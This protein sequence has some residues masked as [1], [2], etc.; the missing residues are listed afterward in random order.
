[1]CLCVHVEGGIRSYVSLWILI[2]VLK[3]GAHCAINASKE[4]C[5]CL[6]L[7]SEIQ[8]M[9]PVDEYLKLQAANRTCEIKTP[10]VEGEDSYFKEAKLLEFLLSRQCSP[11]Q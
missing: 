6:Y 10:P 5:N 11:Q 2:V 4:V 8:K 9:L 3:P 1:V 7:E